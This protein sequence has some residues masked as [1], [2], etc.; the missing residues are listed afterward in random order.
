MDK[1]S[2]IGD[3]AIFEVLAVGLANGARPGNRSGLTLAAALTSMARRGPTVPGAGPFEAPRL[4]RLTR[5]PTLPAHRR[6]K[7][8]SR[9]RSCTALSC[10]WSRSTLVAKW[11][12]SL[13]RCRRTL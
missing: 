13:R 1:V 6:P 4:V 10:S 11:W 3:A 8:S 9:A 5:S 12:P 2:V 7:R